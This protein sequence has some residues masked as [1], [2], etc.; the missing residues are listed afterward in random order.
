MA[1]IGG[2]NPST[3]WKVNLIKF[4]ETV[5]PKSMVN[6]LK[7]I[8]KRQNPTGLSDEDGAIFFPSCAN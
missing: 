2:G 4:T 5:Q 3:V 8:R 7:K 6:A 1:K